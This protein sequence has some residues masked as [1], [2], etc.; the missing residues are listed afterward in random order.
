MSTTIQS[1]IGG[2]LLDPKQWYPSPDRTI[3]SRPWFIPVA[4]G[5]FIASTMLPREARIKIA[6][7]ALLL[8]ISQTRAVSCGDSA[9]D[10]IVTSLVFGFVV[11]F[12]DFGLLR[13]D[14][15]LYKLKE[16]E[17]VNA[18]PKKTEVGDGAKEP[19]SKGIWQKFK[20]SVEL[21]LF[22]MR[23]IGWNWEVGGIPEREPQSVHY[24]LFRTFLRIVGTFIAMD[25]CRHATGMFPYIQ[26]PVRTAFFAQPLLHQVILT[27]LHQLEAFCVINQPYQ[28]GAFLM[29]ALRLQTPDDWPPLFGKL[30]DAYLISRAWGRTWH[31]LMRRPLGILTPYMQKWLG[32]TSRGAKRTVSLFCSFAMSGFVHWAGALNSPWTPTSHGM[33]TYFIMQVPVIRMEDYVVD[34]AKSRGIK[35]NILLEIIGYLWTFGFISFS[36]RYAASYQFETGGLSHYEPLKYSL[37]DWMVG[38]TA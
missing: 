13:K 17:Q 7:P 37:I 26:S 4:Q 32:T 27:W 8:L 35:G 23:G 34:W 6:I 15:E 20:D 10:F 21:W 24:F 33:F 9:R 25:V 11:K 18:Q 3:Q 2:T 30:S 1:L 12:V 5:A 29:V 28:I 31:Q 19:K 22:T 14:G 38:Q 16:R 36:M